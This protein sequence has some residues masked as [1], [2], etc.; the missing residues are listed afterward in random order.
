MAHK[1][2]T[3]KADATRRELLDAALKV[4]AERGYTAATVDHIV[5]A[6]GVSKM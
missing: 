3:S 4:I 1:R 5:E 2:K 6:A